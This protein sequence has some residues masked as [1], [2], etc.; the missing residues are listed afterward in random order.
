MKTK[1]FAGLALAAMLLTGGP[2]FAH[3]D[4]DKGRGGHAPRG[5]GGGHALVVRGGGG[6]KSF[7]ASRGGGGGKSF[8]FRG[9][10]TRGSRGGAL[11]SGRASGSRPSVA[12]GGAG[13]NPG[14]RANGGSDGRNNGNRGGYSGSGR[15]GGYGGYN[16]GYGN[17]WVYPYYGGYPY[18]GYNY[19]GPG[20]AYSA[21]S[22]YGYNAVNA[23]VQ[24][25]LSRQGYYQGPIDGIVGPGTQAA[26]AAYQ[27]D[28]GLPVTGAVDGGLI[29]SLG[30]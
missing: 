16:R 28:N 10:G 13:Y 5:G 20:Y 27:R 1:L 29:H 25:A 7:S 21:P 30:I 2:V 3:G 23:Q 26:I 12:F 22:D 15:G 11:A 6:G 24:E 9:G 14:V 18:L 19:Y 17:N 8:A 4:K